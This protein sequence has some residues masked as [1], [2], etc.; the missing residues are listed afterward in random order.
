MRTIIDIKNYLLVPATCNY[1]E[2]CCVVDNATG[3]RTGHLDVIKSDMMTS[4][5]ER[6]IPQWM[7]T[8]C[9]FNSKV[10][11]LRTLTV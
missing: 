4:L 10:A 6:M 2:L 3:E 1:V 8:S 9:P 11:V 7:S 5:R